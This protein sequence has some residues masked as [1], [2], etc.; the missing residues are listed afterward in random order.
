MPT[1][2]R[3][4]LLVIST[5][6]LGACRSSPQAVSDPLAAARIARVEQGLMPI[7]AQR[8]DQGPPQSIAA[9]MAALGVPGLSVAVFDNGRLLWARGYGM[10][11]TAT[12]APV[13]TS[14]LFQAASISKPVTSAALFKL[15]ER[16]QVALDTDVNAQLRSWT[17]PGNGFTVVEKVTPRRII[18]HMAGLTVHGFAGYAQGEPLPRVE[19]ILDGVAPANSQPVRVDLVPGTQER[20]S[21]G[22]FTVLQLLMQDATGQPFAQLM[23]ALMLEPAGMA[24]SSFAQPLPARLRGQAAT[25]Y[26]RQ[27]TAV[28]GRFHVYPEL[29]AA[30]LW[31]TPSDLGNFMLGIGRA[32]RGEPGGVLSQASARAMLTKVPGGSGQGFGLSGEGEAFRYRHN[33]GNAGFSCYAVAFADRGRAVVLMTNSDNGDVLM[34]EVARAISREYGWP[35]LWV[36]D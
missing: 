21:G 32:Y 19:Q 12:H 4:M 24:H 22:G 2:M 36:R 35:P 27:G 30:G 26:D 28:P 8:R 17:L 20:Y 7:D 18:T 10:R 9:R 25:G 34:H 23:Q 15:V 31:S 1:S 13:E 11:D 14:T 16:G 33:G 29:A 6:A 3:W 5:L